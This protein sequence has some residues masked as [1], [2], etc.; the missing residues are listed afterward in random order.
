MP[1]LLTT[2]IETVTDDGRRASLDFAGW[3]SGDKLLLARLRQ[4][5]PIQSDLPDAL[6]ATAQR[7][8]R[9]LGLRIVL[10]KRRDPSLVGVGG[11][12]GSKLDQALSTTALHRTLGGDP[13]P[14][15][16]GATTR[17]IRAMTAIRVFAWLVVVAVGAAA[18]VAAGCLLL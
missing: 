18:F 11:G 1:T 14:S 10:V 5:A 13:A 12:V 4:D 8:V 6:A 16:P 17:Y 15:G 3:H 7:A 9:D 2:W